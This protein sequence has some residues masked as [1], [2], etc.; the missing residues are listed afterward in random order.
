MRIFPTDIELGNP[1][2]MFAGDLLAPE[3][4]PNDPRAVHMVGVCPPGTYV[5]EF[6]GSLPTL[7]TAAS[8]RRL[9][10]PYPPASI[11]NPITAL[12][13]GATADTSGGSSDVRAPLLSA[14]GEEVV[15]QAAGFADEQPS[16]HHRCESGFDMM[17]VAYTVYNRTW[18]WHSACQAE[19]TGQYVVPSYYFR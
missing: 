18:R 7:Y 9:F 8:G 15:D 3:A 12:M 1:S 10:H 5:K 17:K 6:R 2:L 11:Y 19:V 14:G 16:A 4:R 13:C